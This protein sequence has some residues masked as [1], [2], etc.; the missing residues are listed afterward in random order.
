M[1]TSITDSLKGHLIAFAADQAL[2]ENRV[3]TL[4]KDILCGYLR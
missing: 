2:R 4:E 1:K 3:V